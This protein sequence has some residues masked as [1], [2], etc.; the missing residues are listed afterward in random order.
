MFEDGVMW[1]A[2]TDLP[3]PPPSDHPF[4][5]ESRF[6]PSDRDGARALYSGEAFA[7]YLVGGHR[8]DTGKPTGEVW[9]YDLQSDTWVNALRNVDVET[10]PSDPLALGFDASTETLVAVDQVPG[11]TTRRILRIDLRSKILRVVAELPAYALAGRYSLVHAGAGEYLLLR[12]IQGET[13]FHIF[14]FGL[15]G[16]SVNWIG[17]RTE[18]GELLDDAFA[19]PVGV[20]APVTRDGEQDFVVVGT[21]PNTATPSSL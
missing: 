16:S 14:R 3:A 11:S 8:L 19:T 21:S 5:G 2:F 12:Q 1:L 20:L 9:R 17:R 10:I 15:A 4:G 18:S 7:V 13:G 6:V